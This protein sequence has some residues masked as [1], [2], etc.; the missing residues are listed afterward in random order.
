MKHF[1]HTLLLSCLSI[2]AFSQGMVRGYVYDSD[3]RQPVGGATVSLLQNG[4]PIKKAVQTAADGSYTFTD[5]PQGRYAVRAAAVGYSIVR[6]SVT[7]T[8]TRHD[9]DVDTIFLAT[10]QLAEAL[11]QAERPT[12]RLEADRRSY[13][14]DQQIAATGGTATEVLENIPSVEVDQDGNISLRGNTAVEVWING[15]PSGLTADNR[16]EILEQLPAESIDRIEVIDNPPAKYSAEGS[17]GIINIVLKQGHRAGYY[18]SL[19]LGGNTDGGVNANGSIN[20]SGGK[21]E[22]Y[23]NLGLRHRR[24][25]RG[26][27]LSEQ[28]FP[29]SGDYQYGSGR[30]HMR[31]NNLFARAGVTFHAT[32]HDDFTLGGHAMIGGHNGTSFTDYQ[33]GNLTTGPARS[34]FRLSN[35]DGDMRMYHAEFVYKHSF[36]ESHF[37][38]AT[39]E[40]N[41]WSMDDDN[42]Y[43]DSTWNA[44]ALYALAYN[45]EFRPNRI[46]N[47]SW[48]FRLDY[49]NQFND[50]WKLQAGYN[51]R[52]SHENTPQH[53]YSSPDWHGTAL[54]EVENYFNRFIYDQDTHALYATL[55]WTTG[56]FSAQAGLRGEYWKVNTE[57]YNLAMENDASLRG[58]PFKKDYFELFPSLFLSYQITSSQQLQLNYT[59]RLR[60][61]WGGQLNS[62]KNTRDATV[63]EYGNP[64]LTPE[65]S[66]NFTLN[67]IKT[68][69]RH[70][71]SI[72]AYYRPT[73]EVIQRIRYRSEDDGLMYMTSCNVTKRTDT[74]IEVVAKNKLFSILDLTTTANV[75]Y[76]HIDGFDYHIDG[77]TVSGESDHSMAWSLRVMGLFRLP[78]DFSLQATGNL[79]S[80]QVVAQG[81]RRSNYNIDLGLR[82]TFLNRQ[83]S[84]SLSLRDV[85]NSRKFR[86]VSNSADFTRYQKGWRGGRSLQVTLTW[87]FG[88]MKRKPQPQRE[89]DG[90]DGDGDTN[91]YTGESDF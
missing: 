11:V 51:G 39:A 46:R 52:L 26:G 21:W 47:R 2:A 61:P 73:T 5:V 56:A 74:G 36:S 18:G 89:Q 37:L 88:N 86:V 30:R 40:Y 53:A 58:A 91:S 10:R 87:N 25:H 24:N 55:S 50:A 14:V 81:Y 72:G 29:G 20:Y 76:Q 90:M 9:A 85:F 28:V 77:Q 65:F 60:R 62:F 12:M 70:T 27:S 3:E 4:A 63:I 57:S 32:K 43:Q 48:E 16:G 17:A 59:R 19:S 1:L 80:R 6:R 64:Q 22:A 45:Y 49:E 79:R 8:A 38:E 54:T 44:G 35:S 71:L 66:N 7:L 84:V 69:D 13:G 75:Y 41:R 15:R 42:I 67:Y 78:A 82:K 68:W 34:M 33:Y 83:L 23:A 31:G